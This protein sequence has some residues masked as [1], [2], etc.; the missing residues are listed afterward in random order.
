VAALKILGILGYRY[1]GITEAYPNIR[2]HSRKLADW[3]SLGR[4]FTLFGAG[5]AGAALDMLFSH[6]LAWHA[7]LVG[8]ALALLQAGGQ[9]S[10]QA[11]AEEVEIDRINRKTYRPTVDGR[12]GLQS[13]KIF[14]A[15][16][17]LAGLVLAFA[18][19]PTFGF[20]SAIL[21]VF[22][23]T[24]TA[25]PF[26]VKRHF[27]VNNIHQGVARGFLPIVAVA[28]IYGHYTPGVFAFGLALAVWVMG[29]Q[30]TKD[31]GDEAGDAAYRIRTFPVVLG[32]RRAVGLMAFL[33]A[34]GFFS[35][36][37]AMAA[38]ILPAGF[39]MVNLLVLPSWLIVR[40]L[41]I[42]R[43]GNL[44][45]FK[46]AENSASWVGFYTTMGLWYLIPGILG[47]L[48]AVAI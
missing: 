3:I 28:G 42:G 27:M 26:R 2:R 22:A 16:L 17:F 44:Y 21:T 7:V 6:A 46:F 5:L 9:V 38:R 19:S 23:V 43:V 30:A 25:P 36:N 24:Y 13:A 18:L 47:V 33:M 11:V 14:A 31:F 20:I 32:R 35:L 37:L 34:M 1:A 41:G 29:A 39:L 10:N 8:L 40:G 4:P 45:K 48:G 15:L 12:I